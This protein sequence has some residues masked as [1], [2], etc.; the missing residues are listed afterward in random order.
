ME[1]LPFVS[2]IVLNFNGSRLGTLLFDCIDSLLETDYPHFEVV[3]ADSGSTDNSAD[4][5]SKHYEKLH[6]KVR[7]I[8]LGRD[9]GYAGGNDAAIEYGDLK[10]DLIAIVNDDLVVESAWL[11]PL[12]EAMCSEHRIGACGPIY[13]NA[14]LRTVENA[15]FFCSHGGL[16]MRYVPYESPS[17][18]S[19]K[20]YYYS[21]FAQGACLLTRVS[22]F[23]KLGGFTASFFLYVEE[24]DF[25]S[26]LRSFGFET[27]I[28]SSSR[29][30][31]YGELKLAKGKSPKQS[32][33]VARNR[34][35]YIYQNRPPH[36]LAMDI[37]ITI[38]SELKWSLDYLLSR[39]LAN[40]FAVIRGILHGIIR[41]NGGV[42]YYGRRSF[43]D[44]TL[45][46]WCVDFLSLSQKPV[47]IRTIR[48]LVLRS[49]HRR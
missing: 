46:P 36:E 24:M 20:L 17:V 6:E 4:E 47:M 9:L 23:R 35:Y 18:L 10:G 5:I 44:R 39:N 19:N 2:L 48:S 32:F 37:Y 29:V 43:Y 7:V 42:A 34:F 41:I 40:F 13:L 3:I 31:H 12:V 45:L 49:A 15:G 25:C 28:V 33:Y 21:S 38:I 26:R 22:L 30:V 8:K 16:A 11:S 14:D 1:R 27:A